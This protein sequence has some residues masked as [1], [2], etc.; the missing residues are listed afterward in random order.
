MFDGAAD[1]NGTHFVESTVRALRSLDYS[2]EF[3]ADPGHDRADADWRHAL[4]AAHDVPILTTKH[5]VNAADPS[6]TCYAFFLVGG[7]VVP[8]L[9]G[10]GL[11]NSYVYMP[12]MG[13]HDSVDVRQQDW[14]M[15]QGYDYV[16][17]GSKPVYDDYATQSE[18]GFAKLALSGRLVPQVAYFGVSPDPDRTREHLRILLHRG[19]LIRPF[20]HVVTKLQPRMKPVARVQLPARTAYQAVIIEP[21]HHFAFRF[22]VLNVMGH[23][24]P[25]WGLRVVHGTKNHRFVRALLSDFD[26]VEYDRVP[27]SMMTSSNVNAVLKSAAFWESIQADTIL[28]FQTDAVVL[29]PN[30]D[31]FLHYD[32]IGPP[33][34]LDNHIWK[35]HEAE[36]PQGVGNGGISIRSKQSALTIIAKYGH[37]TNDSDP[38]DL[39][40]ARHMLREGFA[41]PS[42]QV[43]ATFGLE[44]HLD[45]VFVE[46]PT[47]LHAAW[48]YNPE[49]RVKQLLSVLAARADAA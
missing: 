7:S 31:D 15:L 39:F 27:Y 35:R 12:G 45:D 20:R 33:W 42:R 47:G 38:E 4:A 3:W 30:I 1:A 37:T 6:M 24:S 46:V 44:A 16:V 29:K 34:H 18:H 13:A 11:L 2:V 23:L 8:T 10:A 19:V 41:L 36:V 48:Y 21:R 26:N 43:A 17:V 49:A 5:A 40:F 14:S 22:C 32:Y 25:R 28:H 9:R